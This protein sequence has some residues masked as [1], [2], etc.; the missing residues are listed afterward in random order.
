M[1]LLLLHVA[2]AADCYAGTAFIGSVVGP[3][4]L[5]VEGGRVSWELGGH[6]PSFDVS[7]EEG[8]C[9]A[10]PAL[11]GEGRR[12]TDGGWYWSFPSGLDTVVAPTSCEHPA[13]APARVGLSG[14]DPTFQP[15]LVNGLERAGVSV[16]PP[17]ADPPPTWTVEVGPVHFASKYTAAA[18]GGLWQTDTDVQLVVYRNVPLPEGVRRVKVA[19]RRVEADDDADLSAVL[20]DSEARSRRFA[21]K[22]LAEKAMAWLAGVEGL[23][24][25]PAL[26]R[27]GLFGGRL[28][29]GVEVHPRQRFEVRQGDEVVGVVR[30]VGDRGGEGG[31]VAWE[32]LRWGEHAAVGDPLVLTERHLGLLWLEAGGGPG[33][34]QV[35]LGAGG[36]WTAGPGRL[37]LAVEGELLPLRGA[38]DVVGAVEAGWVFGGGHLQLGPVAAAGMAGRGG[39]VLR[40]G[41][42]VSTPIGPRCSLQSRV[43]ASLVA[44]EAPGF[45]VSVGVSSL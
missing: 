41:L 14:G 4:W 24:P 37:L 3:A 27:L 34:A 13:L 43:R 2:L 26:A 28:E 16:V 33:G 42:W 9:R 39:G 7:C 31:K 44:A 29:P 18:R 36:Q 5:R 21:A 22:M 30:V 35:A 6:T 25:R 40:P 1:I 23:A 20:V 11:W 32:R 17:G 8:R 10:H 45:T 38:E 15:A 12:T 19:E